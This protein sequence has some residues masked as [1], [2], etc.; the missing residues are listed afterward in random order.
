MPDEY[1]VKVR[2]NVGVAK[3]FEVCVI[4]VLPVF[5]AA[6]QVEALIGVLLQ[7]G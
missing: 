4:Q 1:F 3:G 5:A 7:E 6:G 2:L